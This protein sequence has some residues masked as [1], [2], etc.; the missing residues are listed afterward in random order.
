MMREG[1][2]AYTTSCAWLGYSDEQLTQ[3]SERKHPRLVFKQASHV[4]VLPQ[5]CTDALGKG[6]T[7]FKVKVGAN[8]EE[9]RRRCRLIR[10]MIGPSNTLVQP[11]EHPAV[12]LNR[13][14]C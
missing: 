3:V 10:E 2:P 9:D 7:K 14:G 1:Y 11:R 6:W 12:C 4:T 5:L 13:H 8:L